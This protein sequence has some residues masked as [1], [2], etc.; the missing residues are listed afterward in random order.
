[1][2]LLL[3]AITTGWLVS[4][5]LASARCDEPDQKSESAQGKAP[6]ELTVAV[7]DFA[8]DAAGEPEM[9][10]QIGELLTAMLSGEPGFTLVDRAALQR[11][12]QETELNLTGLVS[13]EQAV[14]VGK[15]VGARILVVGKAFAMGKKMF[16]TAKL[17][18]TETSLVE[19]VIV[20][21]GAN[22]DI[23]ELVVE[24]AEKLAQRLREAG[25]KLV[26]Q[27]GA[28]QDPLPALKVKLAKL[29][30]PTVAV[31]IPERHMT[32]WPAGVPDPAVETE[33]KKLLRE[34]GFTI[35]DVD[36]NELAE[37]ARDFSKRDPQKWPRSLVGVDVVIVGEGFS[38]FG[39]RIGNLISCVARAEINVISRETG[40]V[41]LADRATERGVD[42][43]Q[44]IAGKKA[45]QKAGRT[46][47][48]RVLEYFAKPPA[49]GDND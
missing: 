19:G 30:K 29:K 37:F 10:K 14:Q 1:M 17:I 31:I 45:L 23:G 25:P 44:N 9:G 47:G 28:G 42:L 4:A 24:L 18:G 8:A 7:L 15:L 32:T 11:S 41:L 20:K 35:Q 3:R 12:L 46:L 22:A 27:D 6:R 33:I 36:Q 39:A 26:A 34:C 13:T 5:V 49:S 2:R 43:S 38:E 40:E 21:D 16:I 48:I